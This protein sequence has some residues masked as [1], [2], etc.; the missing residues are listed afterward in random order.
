[1]KWEL[2]PKGFDPGKA[3]PG[4]LE[5][6]GLPQTPD[7]Q[8]QPALNRAWRRM[9]QSPLDWVEPK[10]V[11][12]PFKL[13]RA[14]QVET[15]FDIAS[16]R[17]ED[18]GNWAGAAIVPDSDN[19]FVQVFGE[20]T[21]PLPSVPPLGPPS[22]TT[23]R[24]ALWI[25]LD[26][27]RRYFNS[28]MPQV[29][30]QQEVTHDAAGNDTTNYY[31]WFQW[32]LRGEPSNVIMLTGLH[33]EAGLEMM[34]LV[35]AFDA[36]DVLV[37]FRNFGTFNQITGFT[38]SAPPD[39]ISNIQPKVS[40]ATAE[41]ILERPALQ[42]SNGLEPFASYLPTEFRNCV[43]GVAGGP[44]LPTSEKA[45]IAPRF[46]RMFERI[47]SLP[48]RTRII[49]VPVRNPADITKFALRYQS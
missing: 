27:D 9:F 46:K 23:Y 42:G 28:S 44:G 5:A 48:S 36:T 17:I 29:G 33:V 3:T 39:P 15:M 21:V 45:L 19:Q 31:A 11:Q 25:G 10:R 24:N 32:W 30:T 8:K 49:S 18:S 4:Q 35:W 26:G 22:Q 2:P 14:P 37:L 13:F 40:G 41:W 12:A 47:G 6:Y 16:T 7:P 20:W 43:A 1:M 38:A 34:G